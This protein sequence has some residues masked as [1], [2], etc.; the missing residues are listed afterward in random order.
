MKLLNQKIVSLLSIVLM[1]TMVF[2]F[3]AIPTASAATLNTF[4][5]INIA[6][7]PI[8][9][10][11]K[12]AVVVWLDKVA[13]DGSTTAAVTNTIRFNN[14]TVIVKS[15]DGN[16]SRLLWNPDDNAN[17]TIWDTTSSQQTFFTPTQ[18][19]VYTLTFIFPTQTIQRTSTANNTYLSS[20]ATTTLTVQEEP[21]PEPIYSYPLPTEYW[22]RPIEGQNTYWYLISSNWY[23]S[24]HD[25]NYG[26]YLNNRYQPSGIGPATAHI[27]WA[28]PVAGVS[29][30]RIG[31]SNYAS[32]FYSNPMFASQIIMNGRL[33]YPLPNSVNTSS[34]A[35]WY[36]VDLRTGQLYLSYFGSDEPSFGAYLNADYYNQ[37]GVLP[38]GT[39]FTANFTRGIDA[40]A[41][42]REAAAQATSLTAANVPN[43]I[44]AVGGH[45]EYLRFSVANIRS[46][47]N[48]YWVV[49]QWN[50][51]RMWNILTTN[52]ST[53]SPT[54][55]S[56][57]SYFDFWN[58]T[59][60]TSSNPDGITLADD[61]VEAGLI[62]EMDD[63]NYTITQSVLLC[64]NGTLPSPTSSAP[65]TYF[66]ISLAN[67]TIN[68]RTLK[69]GQL[70]WMKSYD[71]PSGG[72]TLVPGP[73]VDGV[74]TMVVKETGKWMG[75]DM[76]TG[77]KLWE[78][79]PQLNNSPYAY[80]D[81]SGASGATEV[82]GDGKLFT[83]GYSGIVYCYDLKNGSLLWNKAFPVSYAASV[84][85]YPT[86]I[87]VVCDGKIYLGTYNP[88]GDQSLLSG[89]MVYCLNATT[90]AEIWSMPSFGGPGGFAVADGY[91]VY[92]NYYDLNVYSVGKGPSQ[93][94]VT[95]SPDFALSG[96]SVTVKGTC[97]DVSPGSSIKGSAA[98]SDKD[99]GAWM[100]Y[101]FMNQAKPDVVGVDVT[102]NVLD[103]NGNQ[104][105]IGTATVDMDGEFNFEW[106]P[107][108]PGQYSVTATFAGTESY[109]P[110]FAHSTFYVSDETLATAVPTQEPTS[111][112]SQTYMLYSTGAIV[113]TLAIIA[114]LIGLAFRK[115]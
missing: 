98:I 102:L 112:M 1:L 89:A 62:F 97:T 61:T 94:T 68:G 101:K 114:I 20:N 16:T 86:H 110:S 54:N 60:T 10:G 81:P 25:R 79:E 38:W 36:I 13:S 45:G 11:Q 85:N 113:A 108:V 27:M 100:A 104:Y 77:N 87:G 52:P 8:G 88:D 43:G 75:F 51:S 50:S 17:F 115:R 92:L 6:P 58:V 32:T 40:K 42:T 22:T 56:G 65:Y 91:M 47:A 69:T 64:R 103:P 106:T 57:T 90:G 14:Y 2:S 31:F 66:A 21:I 9:V 76:L 95:A 55:A 111:S 74:W 59:V 63:Y 49:R 19:G 7:N 78:T 46:V 83:A 84:V 24:V 109:W 96:A 37:H 80:T 4:A 48:P 41:L 23:N 3:F 70:M 99:M 71:A 29:T 39:I 67:Q 107:P 105:D 33:Y 73:A 30:D 53:T 44:E 93:T 26:G 72:Y 18:A 28:N 12:A 5:Y 34:S 82:A 15:P 35:G